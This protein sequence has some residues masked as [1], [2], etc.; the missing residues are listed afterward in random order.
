MHLRPVGPLAKCRTATKRYI[1]HIPSLISKVDSNDAFSMRGAQKRRHLKNAL[2]IGT[3]TKTWNERLCLST[4]LVTSAG[5]SFSI[6]CPWKQSISTLALTNRVNMPSLDCA[7]PKFTLLRGG[8]GVRLDPLRTKIS[9]PDIVDHRELK[10]TFLGD[11]LELVFQQRNITGAEPTSLRIPLGLRL[12]SSPS[13]WSCVRTV[14]KYANAGWTRWWIWAAGPQTQH[15][16]QTKRHA[17]CLL[18]SALS[19]LMRYLTTSKG[20]LFPKS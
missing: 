16:L 12:E 17:F 4:V 1:H 19:T 6:P 3:A 7:G 13:G 20:M 9:Y 10:V 15:L 11:L 8:S 18:I 14:P 2:P 5:N